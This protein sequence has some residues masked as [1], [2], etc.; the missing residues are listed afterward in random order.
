MFLIEYGILS[1]FAENKPICPQKKKKGG[2]WATTLCGFFFCTCITLL[3][4]IL[5]YYHLSKLNYRWIITRKNLRFFVFIKTNSVNYPISKLD[6]KVYVA[7]FRPLKRYFNGYNE[8]VILK[9]L[10]V[11]NKSNVTCLTLFFLN[12]ELVFDSWRYSQTL[13]FIIKIHSHQNA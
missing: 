9:L 7:G 8:F 2:R 12:I 13:K 10:P 6:I 5:I 3:R 11:N 1:R 4:G